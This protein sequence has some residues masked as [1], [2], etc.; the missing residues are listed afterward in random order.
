LFKNKRLSDLFTIHVN[1]MICEPQDPL[2]APSDDG[3]IRLGEGSGE[4]ITLDVD[5]IKIDRD[6][7]KTG[8]I[9]EVSNR[10]DSDLTVGVTFPVVGLTYNAIV[11]G[12]EQTKLPHK[13]WERFTLAKND[14]VQLI[15]I[16][17]PDNSN[18][19]A[20]LNGS[21]I[22]VKVWDGDRIKETKS[23][24]IEVD[25]ELTEGTEPMGPQPPSTMESG[26]T[27]PPSGPTEPT[28]SVV[29]STEEPP[30]APKPEY[31]SNQ[32][33]VEPDDSGTLW[34]WLFQIFNFT[35]LLTLAGYGIFFMLPKIQVLE[36]RLAKSEMF[37]HGSREAIREELDE[38]KRE[39]LQQC[40]I[41]SGQE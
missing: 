25:P 32:R 39:I 16:A 31:S 21:Q 35:L 11:R 4:G 36:D 3:T 9:V 27:Q 12:L 30:P 20:Q 5:I 15:V 38:I 17:D 26:V 10:S 14:K 13:E 33:R 6:N 41:Q 2:G 1:G 29:D 40:R 8:K 7:I 37:I 22:I 23:I 18:R 24:A 28:G 34:L 19:L